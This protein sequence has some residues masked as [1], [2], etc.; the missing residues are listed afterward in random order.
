M[1]GGEDGKTAREPLNYSR[2]RRSCGP[3]KGPQQ[4][5]PKLALVTHLCHCTINFVVPHNQRS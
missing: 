1:I 4:P 3:K 5:V 2:Y